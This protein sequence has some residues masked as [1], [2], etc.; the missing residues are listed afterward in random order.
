MK[1]LLLNHVSEKNKT[2]DNKIEQKKPQSDFDRHTAK[3]SALSS[4]VGKY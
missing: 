1:N 3:I 2:M 4:D